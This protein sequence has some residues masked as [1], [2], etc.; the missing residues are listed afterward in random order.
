MRTITTSDGRAWEV[1]RCGAA[2]GVLWIALEADAWDGTVTEAAAY[3]GDAQVTRV[4]RH[5]WDGNDRVSYAGY[6][7][8]RRVGDLGG[9]VEI[10][11]EEV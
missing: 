7:R 1:T 9:A 4:I 2:D 11:L 8:L 6:T 3:W 5:D 10:V